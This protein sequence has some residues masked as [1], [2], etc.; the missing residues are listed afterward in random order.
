[1][2]YTNTMTLG[3][4]PISKQEDMQKEFLQRMSA[5]D[6]EA[7][8]TAAGMDG[9]KYRDL[10]VA[11]TVKWLGDEYGVGWAT[12]PEEKKSFLLTSYMLQ[13]ACFFAIAN[14]KRVLEKNIGPY[15]EN[16]ASKDD[17]MA[18]SWKLIK[19]KYRAYVKDSDRKPIPSI[20]FATTMAEFSLWSMIMM[21]TTKYTALEFRDHV[22]KDF[23]NWPKIMQQQFFGNFDI[24]AAF[25]TEHRTW[26]EHLWNNE[27]SDTKNAS[28]TSFTQ[29]FQTAFYANTEEDALVILGYEMNLIT[30]AATGGF[31]KEEFCNMMIVMFKQFQAAST[32]YTDQVAFMDFNAHAV[33]ST[34]AQETST[35]FM[36]RTDRRLKG[37]PNFRSR[38]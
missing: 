14:N 11:H 16:R 38:T 24:D 17:L 37:A 21:L 7:I 9:E 12:F 28:N 1:M 34:S 26:A 19:D 35:Q 32:T 23:I 20:K 22:V 33:D 3:L 29:G 6:I 30:P 10:I 18:H 36:A 25:Q 13:V 5:E 27:I 8:L 15:M 4:I 31:T 2:V